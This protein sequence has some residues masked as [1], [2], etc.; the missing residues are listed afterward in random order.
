M[1]D[2]R[3]PN[4]KINK[5]EKEHPWVLFF[6]SQSEIVAASPDAPELCTRVMTAVGAIWYRG[7]VLSDRTRI[8]AAEVR[9][10]EFC[11]VAWQNAASVTP[12][13]CPPWR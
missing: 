5:N 10:R 3:H 1:P 4:K 2:T 8:L 9:R 11:K 12:R 13:F 6:F 7:T